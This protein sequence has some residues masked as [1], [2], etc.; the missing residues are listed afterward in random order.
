MI[1]RTWVNMHPIGGMYVDG[2]DDQFN[3]GRAS[4]LGVES[5]IGGRWA[6]GRGLIGQPTWRT[7][8]LGARLTLS[9]PDFSQWGDVEAGDE[10]P[11]V[12]VHSGQVK[13]GVDHGMGVADLGEP[14]G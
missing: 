13:L 1:T 3:A 4:V 9:S 7:H 5:V 6:L 14:C 11:Y 8:L 10:L 12:R 2:P